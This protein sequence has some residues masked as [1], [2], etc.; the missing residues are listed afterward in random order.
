[1]GRQLVAQVCE[2]TLAFVCMAGGVRLDDLS[3][4]IFDTIHC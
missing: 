3:E 1:M 4:E 2:S